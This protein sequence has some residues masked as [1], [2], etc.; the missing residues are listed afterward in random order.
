[1]PIDLIPDKTPFIGHL[2]EAGFLAGGLV[3]AYLL[4]PA[5]AKTAG[6]AAATPGDPPATLPNFF[7]VGGARCGTTSLFDAIGQHPDVFCCPVKEP[8]FFATDRN[9]RPHILANAMRQGVLLAP[10]QPGLA[11]LPR[12]ATTTDLPTYL[13]LFATWS[14]QRAVGEATT[15]YLCSQ[16]A[17]REIAA[18]CPAARIIVVLRHP[19]QRAQSEFL[20]HAQLGR[21]MGSLDAEDAVFGHPGRNDGIKSAEIIDASLY[22]PQ[23]RRYL[24]A[25]PREQL[26]FLRF[27]DVTRAPAET[28]ARIFAHIGV[29]NLPARLTHHNQS[30][31]VRFPVLNRLLFQSGAREMVLHLL[32]PTLRRRLARRYYAEAPST[33]PS[34]PIDMFRADIEETA[35]LTGLSLSHW[36]G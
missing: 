5:Y 7:L 9:A 4:L 29:P 10:G 36:L 30:R 26:L 12:V 35:R 11:V 16:T 19:V 18:L 23:I 2:D 21:Q 32:P 6:Q 3:A 20:M 22:A 13:S 14:G 8:N 1:M 33:R 34:L 25:F 31:P 27:E 24:A 28:M 17:A 15:S